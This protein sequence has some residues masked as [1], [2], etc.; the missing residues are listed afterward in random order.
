MNEGVFE[1]KRVLSSNGIDETLKD[2]TIE[3][4]MTPA[5]ENPIKGGHL[6]SG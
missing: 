3:A 4:F 1:G 2:Q 6:Q 5:P